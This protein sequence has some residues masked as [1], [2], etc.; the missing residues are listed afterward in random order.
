[1]QAILYC[2]FL[3]YSL[4]TEPNKLVHVFRMAVATCVARSADWIQGFTSF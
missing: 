2:V 3:S 1:M 4:V